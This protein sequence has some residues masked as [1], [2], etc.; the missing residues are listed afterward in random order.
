MANLIQPKLYNSVNFLLRRNPS[1][2]IV[3]KIEGVDGIKMQ[4]VPTS[5]NYNVF[6][7]P[8]LGWKKGNIGFGY[9]QRNGF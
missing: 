6:D 1:W 9:W 5:R 8:L 3:A 7:W 2:G 4:P